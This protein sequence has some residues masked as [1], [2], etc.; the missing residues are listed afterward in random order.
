MAKSQAKLE[1]RP[2][3]NA[4]AE[5]PHK[6]SHAEILQRKMNAKSN[7]AAA[8]REELQRKM[9]KLKEGKMPAE[10]KE[11]TTKKKQFTSRET[12]I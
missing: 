8:A 11:I 1:K 10:Y 4:E 2:E 9:Q 6:L 12:F 5:N 7:N 3:W